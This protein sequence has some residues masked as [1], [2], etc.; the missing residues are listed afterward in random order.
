MSVLLKAVSL[1]LRNWQ[2]YLL[3]CALDVALTGFGVA[4]ISQ[5][6]FA[7]SMS[8]I[9]ATSLLWLVFT[10]FVLRASVLQD[11]PAKSRPD[12]KKALG[13]LLPFVAKSLVL[14]LISFVICAPIFFVFVEQVPLE[15]FPDS[16]ALGTVPLFALAFFAGATVIFSAVLAL[17]GT[18]LPATVCG[19][20][21][22]FSQATT[23][24]MHTFWR[25]FFRI[26]S[27]FAV[28]PLISWGASAVAV[29]S[30]PLFL[31]GFVGTATISMG[32]EAALDYI[33]DAIFITLIMVALSENY[34]EGE[35][36]L[37]AV[38]A[39]TSQQ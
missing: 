29:P 36:L 37:Q 38:P 8:L 1:I 32:L 39:M 17:L 15:L 27:I 21:P 16:A 28:F 11:Q 19:V 30:S 6:N 10:F 26:V 7:L 9:G 20:N 24:G 2:Y 25:S 4:A 22:R 14:Q 18:W 31:A 5:W 23:R 12:G 33:I 34:F 13:A 3:F 35:R